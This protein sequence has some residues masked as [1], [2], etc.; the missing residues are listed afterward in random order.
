MKKTKKWV[1][2]SLI[3]SA[4]RKIWQR[5]PLKKRTLELACVD[6]S[7]PVKQ[8][9]YK[10]E[11]CLKEFRVFDV[12]VDHR[13]ASPSNESLDQRV[14]RLFCG[15]STINDEDN[16]DDIIKL[17]LQCLCNNCHKEKTKEENKN[18]RK[19]SSCK[20]VPKK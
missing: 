14:N 13:V 1:L 19:S 6:S 20:K 2:N 16:I 9:M 11:L 18:R 15:F 12:E 8:R 10:C 17:N 5:S 3:S 4:I 7:V